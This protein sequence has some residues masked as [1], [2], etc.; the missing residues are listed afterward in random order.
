MLTWKCLQEIFKT[1]IGEQRKGY[2]PFQVWAVSPAVHRSV[3]M[4]AHICIQTLRPSGRTHK[5]DKASCGRTEEET[6]ARLPFHSHLSD[7][8]KP[9]TV[10]VCSCITWAILK[11]KPP[12]PPPLC[13]LTRQNVMLILREAPSM[14]LTSR[15]G[16]RGWSSVW[17]TGL[18]LW[19]HCGV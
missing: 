16:S 13:D 2:D 7:C 15:G 17:R 8:L 10:G 18:Q 3:C 14:R 9:F 19:Q 6:R 5:T 4:N 11:T 12:P 1:Q